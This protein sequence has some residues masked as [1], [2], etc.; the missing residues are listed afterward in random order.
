MLLSLQVKNIPTKWKKIITNYINFIGKDHWKQLEQIYQYELDT[1]EGLLDIYPNSEQIFRCFSYCDPKNVKVVILGQDPYHGTNQ[2]TGLC[3]GVPETQQSPP[4]LRNIKKE[5]IS[6]MGIVMISKT[7]EE[8]AKKGVLMLN[9]SLTVRQ[10]SPSSHIKHWLPFTKYIIEY[11]N[12]TYTHIV[13]VAWGAFAHKQ[14][15]HIDQTKHKLIVSSHPSPF[16]AHKTYKTFPAFIGSKP[17][18]NI[19]RYLE[20][21][22]QW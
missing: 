8:W 19:N 7:M 2:A 12:T 1:F 22:I 20:S 11:L 17:F 9:A 21:P 10:K 15:V 16:S 14:M 18:S 5:M 13:F 3:F 4:S 6:D